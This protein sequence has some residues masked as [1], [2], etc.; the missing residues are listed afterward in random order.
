ME[1]N[2]LPEVEAICEDRSRR[3]REYRS[4]GKKVIGYFCCVPVELITAADLIPFRIKGDMKRPITR[5]DAY[6]ET[7]MCPFVRSAFDIAIQGGYD[8][9]D[10]FLVPHGCDNTFKI[11]DIWWDNLQPAYSH[12]INTPHT[13]SASAHAFYKGELQDFRRSL[14]RFTGKEISYDMI[15]HAIE[16]HNK[17]RSLIRSLYELRKNDP[18]GLSGSE[19]M[20]ISIANRSLPVEEANQMLESVLHE[21]KNCQM[22]RE[23]S[24]RL[25]IYG[26]EL[27]DP[28][29]FEMVEALGAQVVTDDLC[30]GFRPYRID[31]EM[32]QDPM[33]ALGRHY[34]QEITCPRTWSERTGTREEELNQ[35]FGHLVSMARDWNVQGTIL[36][37]V[38]Y[39]DNHAFDV[40]DV[41]DYLESGGLRVLHIESDYSLVGLGQ[42]RTRVQAFL[43]MIG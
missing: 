32:T 42:L 9:L 43:E 20:K 19:M 25:M 31:V 1:K 26:S 16:L 24:L 34:L 12:F 14:E 39:C 22:Q 4:R 30:M 28:A 11:Y 2:R 35:R 38:K 37:V 29:F 6:V 5:A 8:F 23:K 33:D 40:P 21:L 27:D 41:A 15:M 3:V 10:G 18:P 7:I 13:T 17:N 36:F